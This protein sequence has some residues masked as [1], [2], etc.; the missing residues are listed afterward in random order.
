MV[1]GLTFF[2]LFFPIAHHESTLQRQGFRNEFSFCPFFWGS[3]RTKGNV[4]IPPTCGP[5]R[6]RGSSSDL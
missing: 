6:R 2:F 1:E 3:P 4:A 5:L